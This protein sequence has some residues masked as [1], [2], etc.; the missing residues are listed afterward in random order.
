MT[1]FHN[2]EYRHLLRSEA[3]YHQWCTATIVE[4]PWDYLYQTI[5]EEFEAEGLDPS[6]FSPR[7]TTIIARVLGF[8][9]A[10]LIEVYHQLSEFTDYFNSFYGVEGIYSSGR[11][12]SVR[13]I[14][15]ALTGFREFEGDSIDRE[16][17]RD[18]LF[19]GVE[20]QAMYKRAG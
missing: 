19:H 20:I 15:S 13:E 3:D 10:Y 7:H 18:I 4:K 11:E 6:G 14:A 1:Y 12:I 8:N 16:K 2:I 17:V 9:E 5:K